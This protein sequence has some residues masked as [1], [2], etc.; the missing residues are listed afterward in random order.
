M[1]FKEILDEL[2]EKTNKL[3]IYACPAWGSRVGISA[4]IAGDLCNDLI[5][6]DMVFLMRGDAYDE[7]NKRIDSTK[8]IEDGLAYVVRMRADLISYG[9]MT[10]RIKLENTLSIQWRWFQECSIKLLQK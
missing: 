3:H 2:Y 7:D 5:I 9:P 4:G 6:D 8:K 10:V 1:A